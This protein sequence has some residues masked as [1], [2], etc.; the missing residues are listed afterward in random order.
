MVPAFVRAFSGADPKDSS[1]CLCQSRHPEG[2]GPANDLAAYWV[3]RRDGPSSCK[4]LKITLR[5]QLR[6]RYDHNAKGGKSAPDLRCRLREQQILREQVVEPSL[7]S[8]CDQLTIAEGI[9]AS[10]LRRV[11]VN[12]KALE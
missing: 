11:A 10:I 2:S 8:G 5:W 12:L 6:K 7:Y 3:Y 9:P 1:P 4:C